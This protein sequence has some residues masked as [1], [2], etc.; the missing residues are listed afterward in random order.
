MRSP[1]LRAFSRTARPNVPSFS[2]APITAIVAGLKS[3][4]R[5]PMP[6]PSF[7]FVSAPVNK[8]KAPAGY[9]IYRKQ[10]YFNGWTAELQSFFRIGPPIGKI[11]RETVSDP[12]YKG[13]PYD[14]ILP[15]TA[16]PLSSRRAAL[17]IAGLRKDREAIMG[18]YADRAM[19]I[20]S[21]NAFKVGP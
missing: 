14:I 18:L 9:R 19:R 16:W 4:C 3:F 1:E 12:C 11:S 20:D 17:P 10:I 15:A 2:V 8:V 6:F 13:R 7:E 21:E 5:S